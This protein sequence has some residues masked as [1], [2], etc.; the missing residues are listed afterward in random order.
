M[1]TTKV[2]ITARVTERMNADIEKI[3]D[4]KGM[5][6]SGWIV[7]ALSNEVMAEKQRMAISTPDSVAKM[8]NAL[9]PDILEQFK[10]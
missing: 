5:T 8:I 4:F 6:K 3:A 7:N 9:A 1:E 10:K 2:R